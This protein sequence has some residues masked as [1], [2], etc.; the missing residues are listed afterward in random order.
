MLQTE[1]LFQQQPDQKYAAET[2]RLI[3]LR[4]DLPEV[5]DVLEVQVLCQFPRVLDP[6]SRLPHH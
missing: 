6:E 3:R 2:E 5:A 1:E 4:P